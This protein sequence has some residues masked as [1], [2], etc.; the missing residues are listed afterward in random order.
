MRPGPN[1][2][3]VGVAD[4]HPLAVEGC[5]ERDLAGHGPFEQRRAPATRGND[6]RAARNADRSKHFGMSEMCVHEVGS[7][8]AY[9][10]M[11]IDDRTSDRSCG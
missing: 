1:S 9:Q 5:R 4:D 3:V 8:L 6:G 2:K 10:S 11:E 7:H